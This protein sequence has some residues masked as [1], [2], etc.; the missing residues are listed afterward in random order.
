LLREIAGK[1]GEI[2]YSAG[3]P[4]SGAD[5]FGVATGYASHH[6]QLLQFSMV[7]FYN[8]ADGLPAMA[9]WLSSQGCRQIKYDLHG[10][11]WL[12]RADDLDDEAE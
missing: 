4:V 8:L 2:P 7:S 10:P 5:R 1:L 11:S 6:G 9:Q 12:G 3:R